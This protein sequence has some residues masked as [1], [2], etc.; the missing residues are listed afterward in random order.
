MYKP[1]NISQHTP[2]HHNQWSPKK[3]PTFQTCS[4]GFHNF[5]SPNETKP[6]QFK[7]PNSNPDKKKLP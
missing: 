1:K 4:S 3:D 6:G 2:I 7:V 5:R